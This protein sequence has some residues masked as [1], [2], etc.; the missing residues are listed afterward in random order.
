[1]ALN[2]SSIAREFWRK[3]YNEN[4]IDLRNSDARKSVVND[5]LDDPMNIKEGWN[6]STDKRF[7]G[8]RALQT[9]ALP[10]TALPPLPAA[11]P[12]HLHPAI[13]PSPSFFMQLLTSAHAAS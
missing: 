8:C 9:V 1:M 7:L 3:I 13:F 4:A 12:G 10:A 2:K 6:K 5:F 11:P